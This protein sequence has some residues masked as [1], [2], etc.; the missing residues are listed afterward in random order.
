MND[1]FIPCPVSQWVKKKNNSITL[2]Q[3]LLD[4]KRILKQDANRENYK[5][6]MTMY[7]MRQRFR[8]WV[9]RWSAGKEVEDKKGHNKI[10]EKLKR[11]IKKTKEY[12]SIKNNRDPLKSFNDKD[13]ISD[14]AY[15]FEEENLN[16]G[17]SGIGPPKHFQPQPVIIERYMN[18]IN[19]RKGGNKVQ[20]LEAR[21][22][23]LRK[24][25]NSLYDSYKKLKKIHDNNA[26]EVF[27][28]EFTTKYSW[29]PNSFDEFKS[30]CEDFMKI[31][32]AYYEKEYEHHDRLI[33]MGI[34][35]SFG[36]TFSMF[37]KIFQKI[38]NKLLKL[39]MVILKQGDRR[40]REESNMNQIVKRYQKIQ[41]DDVRRKERERQKAEKKKEDARFDNKMRSLARPRADSS[42][43]T[44]SPPNNN[45]KHSPPTEHQVK[46][47]EIINAIKKNDLNFFTDEKIKELNTIVFKKGDT[48]LTLLIRLRNIDILKHVMNSKSLDK[49][50]ITK[51]NGSRESIEE[52]ALKYNKDDKIINFLIER[53]VSNYFPL[54]KVKKL[55][56]GYKKRAKKISNFITNLAREKGLVSVDEPKKIESPVEDNNNNNDNDWPEPFEGLKKL[57]DLPNE[58]QIELLN[59]T[60]IR[61]EYVNKIEKLNSQLTGMMDKR[62]KEKIEH[63]MVEEMK[64]YYNDAYGEECDPFIVA[65]ETNEMEDVE[66]FVFDAPNF[67]MNRLGTPSKKTTQGIP[68]PM[69]GLMIA[70]YKNREK[71]VKFLLSQGASITVIEPLS[72]ANVMHW[73]VLL[74]NSNI[75]DLIYYHCKKNKIDNEYEWCLEQKDKSDMTPMDTCKKFNKFENKKEMIHK[76]KMTQI[77]FDKSAHEH[78]RVYALKLLDWYI[79]R[80]WER[81]KDKSLDFGFDFS[82]SSDRYWVEV[83]KKIIKKIEEAIK[84]KNIKNKDKIEEIMQTTRTSISRYE[85][86]FDEMPHILSLKKEYK[87]KSDVIPK[88]LSEIASV[89]NI[90]IEDVKDRSYICKLYDIR[91][92]VIFR[93]IQHSII[94]WFLEKWQSRNNSAFSNFLKNKDSWGFYMRDYF[95]MTP[96]ESPPKSAM[97]NKDMMPYETKELLIDNDFP[98]RSNII[99]TSIIA[100]AFIRGVLYGH[101]EVVGY[102]LRHGVAYSCMRK[103]D[104]LS[105]QVVHTIIS[106][107]P[108]NFIEALLLIDPTK[109]LLYNARQ[110]VAMR[111]EDENL[112]N[113]IKIFIMATKQWGVEKI[114]GLMN[115]K[116]EGGFA[117]DEFLHNTFLNTDFITHFKVDITRRNPGQINEDGLLIEKYLL[118]M[119]R[120]YI[121]IMQL[122][123]NTLESLSAKKKAKNK[124]INNLKLRF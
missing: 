92:D 13:V 25:I 112:K 51:E 36:E 117:P 6:L 61:F 26:W 94:N 77:L 4:I 103:P 32:N 100:G 7:W 119:R 114:V 82:L 83:R 56:K 85:D 84:T 62:T 123:I 47:K 74:P 37:K 57:L 86:Y 79:K 95:F 19:R 54:V 110:I 29:I 15:V 8:T 109:T 108:I 30:H 89:F 70:T 9:V 91:V 1:F 46:I 18:L 104:I 59:Q 96:I 38:E 48:I 52:C 87:K 21:L 101:D 12:L 76:I 10:I 16:S 88:K 67:D 20:K 44:P 122:Y 23:K 58:D 55:L 63:Q 60:N 97:I 93:D 41:R 28:T 98:K 90:P 31:L 75:I 121:K 14:Y 53:D 27:Y 66:R 11:D 120:F 34:L 43:S 73:A 40:K 78:I 107:T 49:T 5:W 68:M 64:K 50:L 124:Y 113:R 111:L 106:D 42:R 3:A 65:C 24:N 39:K 35:L 33:Y 2:K 105:D 102:C 116:R 115:F 69:T 71:I 72:H 17:E 45:Q 118:R 80:R 22:D 99:I 81:R